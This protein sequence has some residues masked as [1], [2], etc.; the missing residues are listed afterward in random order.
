MAV[1]MNEEAVSPVIGVILMVAVTVILAA[2]IASFVFGSAANV[3]KTKIV[4]TTV[5]L[6][7][8]GSTITIMYQ[9]GQDDG[10]LTSLTI[11]APDSTIWYTSGDGNEL[12]DSPPPIRVKP[13]IGASLKIPA[14]SRGWDPGS[15]HV[16]V[17]GAFGDG[18]YQVITDTYL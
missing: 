4:A 15:K 5:Q 18:A 11:T 13:N 2:I 3:Q 1:M 8:D 16:L 17:V 6:D 9:G 7:P 12:V 14:P 10:T